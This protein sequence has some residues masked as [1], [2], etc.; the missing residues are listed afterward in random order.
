MSLS[1]EELTTLDD[2]QLT[3]IVGG[4]NTKMF[5]AW[6]KAVEMGGNISHSIEGPHYPNS[7]HWVGRAIDV[8]GSPQMRQQY[9]NWAKSTNPTELIYQNYHS[10]RGQRRGPVPGHYD[11]VHLAY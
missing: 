3:T 8:H 6:Q 1:D 10:L 4:M 11:H 2:H 7:F 9:F 5:G